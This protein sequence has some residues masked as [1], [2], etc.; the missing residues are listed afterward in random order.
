MLNLI[1]KR[2]CL[3]GLVWFLTASV[4]LAAP[5]QGGDGEASFGAGVHFIIMID[6]SGDMTGGNKNAILNSLPGLLFG[7]RVGDRE[8]RPALPKFTPGRDHISVVYF[9]IVRSPGGGCRADQGAMSVLKEDI[10][11]LEEDWG[12][13]SQEEFSSRLGE[14]L[15]QPCRARA[16]NGKG[17]G[18]YSPI[19]TAPTLVLPYLQGHLPRD[20]WYSKTILI[21][22]TNGEYN[23]RKSPAEELS[24]F[25]SYSIK[26]TKVASELAYQQSHLF[27]FDTPPAWIMPL[28]EGGTS[29]YVSEVKPARDVDLALSYQPSIKLDRQAIS[30]ERLRLAPEVAQAGDLRILTKG[31]N[32]PYAYDPLYLKMRFRGPQGEA[33]QVGRHVLEEELLTNLQDCQPPTCARDEGTVTVPLFGTLGERLSVGADDQP[34][35]DGQLEFVVGMRYLTGLYDHLQIESS[36]RRISLQ[37]ARVRTM[38]G[39]LFLPDVTLDNRELAGQYFRDDDGEVTQDEAQTRILWWHKIYTILLVGLVVLAVIVV[40]LYLYRTKF[41]RRFSPRLEWH[42]S[43]EVVVDFNRPGASRLLAGVLQVSN[44]E[45]APWLGR[46]VG[47]EAQPTRKALLSLSYDF[48][49][50][51]GLEVAGQRPVG[52]I[53]ARGGDGD[54]S[55]GGNGLNLHAEEIVSDGTQIYIFLAADAIQDYRPAGYK[56]EAAGHT[57]NVKLLADMRWR[58]HDG[59]GDRLFHRIKSWWVMS[60]AG[61]RKKEV[62]F[63]LTIKPEEPRKPLVNFLPADSPRL[64]FEPN[65]NVPVGRFRFRSQATHHFA[66]PFIGKKYTVQSYRNGRPL[67]GEPI[68]LERPEVIVAPHRTA[69]VPALL[70]C[71]GETVVNPD[72]VSDLYTFRLNGDFDAASEAGLYA[73]PL[74]RDPTVAEVELTLAYPEPRHEFFWGKDGRLRRRLLLP[75]GSGAD[76]VVLD[77]ASV[78]LES[79]HF[80]FESGDGLPPELVTLV[81]GNSG[82][83]NRARVVVDITT[84]IFCAPEVEADISFEPGRTKDDLLAVYDEDDELNP[85]VEVAEGEPAQKRSVRVHSGII[86]KITSAIIPAEKLWARVNLDILLTDDN[87]K[88]T[89]RSL[90]F[91]V[92][93]GLEQ[94]PGLNWLCIDF[95]T[96]AIAAAMG[97]GQLDG[98]DTI[99]LQDLKPPGGQ[100]Y[101][102]ADGL[103]SES[104]DRNLLPS[105]IICDADIREKSDAPSRPGFP[106]YYRSNLTLTPG[107]P[108]FIGL[109]ATSTQIRND[110]QR[111]IYSLKSWLA[112]APR[113]ISMR[114][115]IRFMENGNLVERESLP[116]EKMVESGFAAL[117]EGY[118]LVTDKYRAD[119]IVLTYPNTFTRRHVEALRDIAFRALSPRFKIPL[120]ER[121]HLISESDA[122]AYHYC[123]EQ[124][125]ERPRGGTERILV[126][127]FGAGTLD[128][129]LIRVDWEKEPTCNPIGWTVEGRN[130]VPVAGNYFDELLARLIDDLLNE[131]GLKGREFIDYKYPI[132][133]DK[134]KPQHPSTDYRA[135]IMNLWQEIRTAKHEWDGASPLVVKVGGVSRGTDVVSR[136]FDERMSADQSLEGLQAAE[137]AAGSGAHL[138]ADATDIFLSIPAERVKSDR[139]IETFLKFVTGTVIDELSHATNVSLS[140]VDAVIVSGRG[141]L[142]PGLRQRVWER[143]PAGATKPALSDKEMKDA[144][145][146]GAIARQELSLEADGS[147]EPQWK[148]KLGV[149][150]NNNE[151]LIL[152]SDWDKPIDLTRSPFFR[153][154]QVNLADPTPREDLRPGSLR[155]HFYIDLAD[156]K[157]RREGVWE[158]T[159]QLFIK[160]EEENGR[161][162]LYLTDREGRQRRPL[163]RQA[164]SAETATSLPWPIGP[165][166]ILEP[167]S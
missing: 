140:E 127:D 133:R 130:G 56:P 158:R 12:V 83:V 31:E 122:V 105:L 87:E 119:R 143:F 46:L 77:S 123:M 73:A 65:Q 96:S 147:D 150:I 64:N 14:S 152:E 92:P 13:K 90:T 48:S 5:Q 100:T 86:R 4:V 80:V 146:R 54:S 99:P 93:L 138:W 3:S 142:W 165:D 15:R 106:R 57:F 44:V 51:S 159:K 114:T 17:P 38:P 111:V 20:T 109:P 144:V 126:Y 71:D 149:L 82:Q 101:V 84:N 115:P 153:I 35:G 32:P 41:H 141:A 68:S 21:V 1:Q 11:T 52:F 29:F 156:Q 148:P 59:A 55:Q 18:E 110:S 136:K 36:Q 7:G 63:P 8:V 42:P 129:S 10:F 162:K 75:D 43:P 89:Q 70:L 28:P 104:R 164:R 60:E 76:E 24:K 107:E 157:I 137:Q 6:D 26:G 128:L 67:G 19:L 69:E 95:G 125:R 33:W 45:D 120:L 134:L 34:P 155:R 81:I 116:L 40:T 132:V 112:R 25:E 37:P 131:E 66:L 30:R 47:N 79:Q 23:T 61:E 2:S 160:K 108:D 117:A 88:E 154:V 167:E 139:R 145:V 94:L 113:T 78:E 97:T 166:Y 74:H 85:R 22:A 16:P 50:Q 9:T 91:K 163:P 58:S 39:Y 72:P 53:S 102:D 27:L 124:M 161:Q 118:L 135:A 98:I 103:N 151:D 62:S 49:E 121:I